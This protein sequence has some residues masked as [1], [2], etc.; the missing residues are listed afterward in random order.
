MKGSRGLV[1]PGG[2]VIPVERIGK[3]EKEKNVRQAMEEANKTSKDTDTI[4][5]D[6]SRLEEGKVGAGIAW[7]D[8]GDDK[9]GKIEVTRRDNRTAGQRR[10]GGRVTYHGKY[11][12][13][14]TAEVDWRSSG[15]GLGG[16]HEAHDAEMAAIVYGLVH[17]YG[18]AEQGHAYTI[19]TDSTAAIDRKSVV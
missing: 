12:S 9:K 17:L 1:F 6:G 7:F 10:E 16:G 15:F 4:W 5:T 14:M 11:R 19:F 13:L 3:E 18:R 8:K 2:V